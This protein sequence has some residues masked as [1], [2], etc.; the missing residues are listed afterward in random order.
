VAAFDIPTKVDLR[1]ALLLLGLVTFGGWLLRPTQ[2]GHP[3]SV[4]TMSI[5]D[6]L[7]HH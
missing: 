3:T 7:D 1:W 2:P 5:G 4:G 6:G